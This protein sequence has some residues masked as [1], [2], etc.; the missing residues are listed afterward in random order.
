MEAKHFIT[1]KKKSYIVLRKKKM[2]TQ[3][4]VEKRLDYIRN[5]D[6]LKGKSSQ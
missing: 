4:N 5:I 3:L 2:I 1:G 6:A